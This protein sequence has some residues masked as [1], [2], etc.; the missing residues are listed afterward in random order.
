MYRSC[1]LNVSEAA[2]QSGLSS[3]AMQH[4][5]R[6]R[7]ITTAPRQEPTVASL[8]PIWPGANFPEREAYDMFGIKF[9]NH[10]NLKRILMYPEFQGHPLRKDYPINRRQPLIGP[11]H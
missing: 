8:V 10:P 4:R 7:M 9:R 2:R 3:P 11:A 1:G 5:L 6:L